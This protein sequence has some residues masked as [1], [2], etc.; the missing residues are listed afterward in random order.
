[1]QSA[2]VVMVQKTRMGLLGHWLYSIY[3]KESKTPRG[4]VKLNQP[5]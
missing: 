2:I 1:M 4:S 5:P 3:Y